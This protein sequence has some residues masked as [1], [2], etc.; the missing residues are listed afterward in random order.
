MNQSSGEKLPR[1]LGRRAFG[2]SA[3]ASLHLQVCICKFALACLQLGATQRKVSLFSFGRRFEC[4]VLGD[5]LGPGAKLGSSVVL[6]TALTWLT[7]A[8]QAD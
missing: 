3:P 1:A 4:C 6:Q 2:Q 5:T 7:P 8:K